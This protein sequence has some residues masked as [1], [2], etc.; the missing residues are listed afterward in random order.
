MN[1]PFLTVIVPCF[2]VEK[3][4]DKCVSSIVNQT[5]HNLEI[6]LIDDGSTD[7]TVAICDEWQ[8]KDQRIKVIHKRNEGLP[9]ARKTGIEH[10]TTEYVTFLD[11]DDWIDINM[12]SDLMKALLSTD[13]DIAHGDVC[14]VYEDGRIVHK[15]DKPNTGIIEVVGRIEGVLLIL[16]DKK[17]RSWLGNKIYRKHL[18]DNIKFPKGR[19]FG[20][21]FIS[22]DLFHKAQKSV[23]L[24]ND[25]YYYLQRNDSITKLNNIQ[26]DIKNHCD[27]SDAWHERYCFAKQYP[28]YRSALPDV[29]FWVLVLGICLLR[30]FI[31]YPHYF[32]SDY[33]YMK[34]K[35]LS[36]ISLSSK[37]KLR[38]NLRTD[39]YL[40]K[41]SPKFYKVVRMSYVLLIKIANK[42]RLTTNIPTD[43][44]LSKMDVWLILK[45][46]GVL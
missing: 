38:W 39:F 2:N 5:Y 35:Q 31:V 42:T 13:S 19:G 20:E 37:D 7:S 15:N 33:F 11:S 17:W 43:Y 45:K 40:L 6:L 23:Y 25:Y 10:T 21:D 46:G 28:E 32:K 41:I 30:N 9:Y 3:Y 12:Y 22:H 27:Y 18:F 1:Q 34:A 16:E 4:V 8:E 24:H 14:E 26:A 44:L 29:K 36:S